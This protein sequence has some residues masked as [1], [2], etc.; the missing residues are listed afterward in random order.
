MQGKREVVYKTVISTPMEM[1]KMKG[2]MPNYLK[3]AFKE[4]VGPL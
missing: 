4:N 3:A 1:K 2:F